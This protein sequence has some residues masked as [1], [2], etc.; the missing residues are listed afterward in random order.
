VC[1]WKS[2]PVRAVRLSAQTGRSRPARGRCRA[3]SRRR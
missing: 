1:G 3:G 2:D